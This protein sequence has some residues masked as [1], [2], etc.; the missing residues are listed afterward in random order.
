MRESGFE[1]IKKSLQEVEEAESLAEIYNTREKAKGS[2]HHAPKSAEERAKQLQETKALQ[3]HLAGKELET[4]PYVETVEEPKV[5]ERFLDRLRKLEEREPGVMEAFDAGV[6]AV[7]EAGKILL[8]EQAAVRKGKIERTITGKVDQTES[9][10]KA[11]RVIL[12]AIRKEFPDDIIFSEEEVKKQRGPEELSKNPGER[13]IWYVDPLD[14]TRSYASNRL[15]FATMLAREKNG[16]LQFGII[17][18]PGRGELYY[19]A[20]GT[21][22][23]LNNKEIRVNDELA[24]ADGFLELNQPTY[25][26]RVFNQDKLRP[27]LFSRVVPVESEAVALAALARGNAVAHA[28]A[29]PKSW[30]V[31]AGTILVI[32]AGGEVTDLEGRPYD[33]RKGGIFTASNG[34]EHRKFIR[35]LKTALLT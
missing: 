10:L 33:I 34:R 22:A 20:R 30:D 1:E 23:F 9:D 18:Q 8:E 7:L 12:D 2:G 17:F 26:N 24:L 31:A 19:A 13:G 11:Q 6:R 4:I 28:A 21:G 5:S 15:N 35:E 16:I 32:E 27:P 14:G 3:R 25:K 29:N